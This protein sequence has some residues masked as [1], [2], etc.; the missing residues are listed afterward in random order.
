MPGAVDSADRSDK[1]RQKLKAFLFSEAIDKGFDICRVARPDSIPD[2]PAR[3]KAFIDAGYQGTMEWMAA[4]SERRADPRVLWGDVRSVVLFGMNYGPDE[5]PRG[6]L[7]MPA[8]Q[9]PQSVL[10]NAGRGQYHAR[11]AL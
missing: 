9:P 2:A 11:H 7:A 4:T 6:V 8:H 3:L 10:A 1:A 5:D